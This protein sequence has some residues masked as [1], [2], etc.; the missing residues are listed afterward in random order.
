MYLVKEDLDKRFMEEAL[1]L[2]RQAEQLNEVPIGA[3]V[4]QHNRIIGRG[5]NRREMDANPLAHAELIA[6]QEAA[7]F[8]GGWRLENCVL[9]VTLEPCPMCAGAIVQSRIAKVVYA[10]ADPK[11]GYAGSLHNTLQ[12]PRLN[13]QT[14]IVSG[15]CQEEASQLLKQFFRRLRK[16]NPTP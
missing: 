16:K 2:A 1:Q 4:V 10:T 12:D 7:R 9:Y 5:Y 15:V 6:I 3:V 8:L 13:H 14:Q 11:S